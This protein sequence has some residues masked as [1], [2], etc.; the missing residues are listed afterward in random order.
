ML[1]MQ[2]SLL[3]IPFTNSHARVTSPLGDLLHRSAAGDFK[4]SAQLFGE[5]LKI[6]YS[7]G[8][9]RA[10]KEYCKGFTNSRAVV[11]DCHIARYNL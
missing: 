2:P 1:S 10:E 3:I 9:E 5:K 6:R 4:L 7:E 11:G 8:A